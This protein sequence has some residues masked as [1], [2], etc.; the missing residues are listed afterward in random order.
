MKDSPSAPAPMWLWLNLLSLDA[1][2]VAI[3]WQDSVARC[4]AAPLREPGRWALGLT[5]WAIYLADRLI[6]IRHPKSEDEAARHRFYR[7]HRTFAKLLLSAVVLADLSIAVFWLQ[8]SVLS[9]GLVAGAAVI[10]YLVGFAFLRIGGAAG[11]TPSAAILFTMGVFLVAWTWA[12]NPWR[13]LGGAA[14]A[15]TALVMGNLILIELWERGRLPARAWPWLLLIAGASLVVGHSTWYGAIAMSAAG[16]A[17]L[18]FWST[19]ISTE[20]RRVLADAVLLTPL[21]FRLV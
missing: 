21:L 19:S 8:P 10:V 11:K 9:N 20:A 13:V 1:P 14:A 18:D 2:L 7:S 3:V 16:L 4:Y 12:E 6:D 15:F 5:V 17:A